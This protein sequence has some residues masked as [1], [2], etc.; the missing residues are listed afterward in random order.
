MHYALETTTGPEGATVRY[1]IE[2]QGSSFTVRAFATGF[3]A[4]LGHNP[5]ISIPDFEGEVRLNPD[6]VEQ[7]TLRLVI[8]AA[9]MNATN[10]VSAKDKEEI[11]RRMQ[12]EVLESDSYP[13][14]GYECS[15]MSASKTGEGQY[16][17]ALNGDL[18][19]H[20]VTRTQAVSARVFLNG[21]SLRVNGEFSVLQSA[22]EIR[23]VTALGG[24]IR[25]KDEL[26]LG[27]DISA[28]KA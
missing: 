22:Y 7:S 27:F 19:L 11:N 20:G 5:T 2:S 16:W 17:M 15:R 4:S 28:R 8:H 13:D 24:T 12:Q 6:A 3:L 10:D 18:T 25:L 1:V 26:K 23:P 21:N 14:I 9:S